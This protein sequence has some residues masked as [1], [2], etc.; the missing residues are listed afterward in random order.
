MK[1]RLVDLLK[2]IDDVEFPNG[3]THTPIAWQA[4]EHEL[5]RQATI[6]GG[7]IGPVLQIVKACYPTATEADLD[8]CVT[9]DGSLLIA[10]AAHAGRKVEWVREAL[11]NVD[12]VGGETAALPPQPST[13]PSSP[14]TNG[15]TSSPKS[16][17]RSAK[18]GGTS[19]TANPTASPT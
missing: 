19:T 15:N 9:D 2:P 4:A 12:A 6:G 17:K 16:R 11:K 18:T 7:G 5:W 8:S 3:T 13:P 10:M 14:K 1:L